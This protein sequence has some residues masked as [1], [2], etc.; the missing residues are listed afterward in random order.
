M[1]S[2]DNSVTT[3]NSSRLCEYVRVFTRACMC[4]CN[5]FWL[6]PCVKLQVDVS[7]DFLFS[8]FCRDVVSLY[9]YVCVLIPLDIIPIYLFF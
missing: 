5:P 7:S 4:A 3:S 1:F 6:E 9:G 2:L 8:Q